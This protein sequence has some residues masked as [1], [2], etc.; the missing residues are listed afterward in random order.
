MRMMTAPASMPA[1]LTVWPSVRPAVLETDRREALVVVVS[2]APAKMVAAP[3]VMV[4]SPD[5]L[6]FWVMVK[7]VESMMDSMKALPPVMP[8]PVT[9]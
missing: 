4:E 5:V 1:P 7:R 9:T 2:R 6:A 8:A 3:R